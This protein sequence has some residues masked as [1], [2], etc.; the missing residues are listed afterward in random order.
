MKIQ[1]SYGPARRI[2]TKLIARFC[3]GM[4]LIMLLAQLYKYDDFASVLSIILPVNNQQTSTILAACIV[5]AE[6]FSFPYLLGMYVS[7]LM[8]V[9]SAIFA[10]SVISFWLISA[11][12]NAHASNSALLSTAVSLQGGVISLL[13]V[14]A[15]ASSLVFV[16]SEDSRFRHDSS[17]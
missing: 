17:S 10:T 3:A 8:R 16:I 12:T 6:L 13:W 1:P 2:R 7:K 14:V 9:V 15:M 4:L 5:F 11:L